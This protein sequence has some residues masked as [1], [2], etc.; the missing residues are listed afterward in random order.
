MKDNRTRKKKNF[1]LKNIVYFYNKMRFSL[2]SML[3]KTS[4]HL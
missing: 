4:F 2:S 3:I 1:K